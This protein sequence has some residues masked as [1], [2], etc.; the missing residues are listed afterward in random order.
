[1]LALEVGQSGGCVCPFQHF[2]QQQ[3]GDKLDLEADYMAMMTS[4]FLPST[5]VGGGGVE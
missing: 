3:V 2:K 4:M 5:A 1:M